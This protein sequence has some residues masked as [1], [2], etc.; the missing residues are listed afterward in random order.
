[1]DNI[2]VWNFE[3]GR[4]ESNNFDERKAKMLQIVILLQQKMKYIEELKK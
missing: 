4:G 3:E 2:L 1:M